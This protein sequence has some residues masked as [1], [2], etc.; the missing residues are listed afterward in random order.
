[1]G[2]I[3]RYD[4]A[5]R[6]LAEAKSF[7]EVRDWEDKAAAV[8]EYGRRIGNR[9]L[10]FDAIEIR[11]IA[12]QRRGQLLLELKAA[13]NLAEGKPKTVKGNGRLTLEELGISRN[14]SA[15]DQKIAKIPEDAFQGLIARCRAYA[16]EHEK[17]TFDVLRP[18]DEP[19][20]GARS[21]MGSRQEPDDSLD[22][23]PTP[24]W[25]TR[26]LME[27]VFPSFWNEPTGFRRYSA[28]EP[29]CGEGHIAEVL[30]EYF[31]EVTA[32]DIFEYGYNDDTG[33]FL[34]VGKDASPVDWII[35]N[36]PF[37]DNALA[38][39]QQ[40][41]KL[42]RVGVAMFF[43]SQWVVEGIERY[44]TIFRS[45]PPTLCAFFVERVNLCKGRWEPDGTTATAYCWL[46]WMKGRKPLPP[47]WI[48]PGCRK[49]LTHADD[50]ERFTARPVV[51]REHA[52]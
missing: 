43:R 17:H 14:E 46:V 49:Q 47:F 35:T 11:Q 2:E 34:T 3:L 31:R 25:A 6:A 8:R 51:K 50:R 21:I 16:A 7:D 23:F 41:I 28:W 1:M 36:P 27:R 39:V 10:E 9:V 12:R 37:G 4:A 48:P 44:E 33:D 40:G 18:P 32:T 5:C 38:F 20:G 52:E 29:A 15:R 26:A 19:I 24:P 42:A 30:R 13:G 45:R 22:Y